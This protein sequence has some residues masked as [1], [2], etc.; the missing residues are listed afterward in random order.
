MYNKNKIMALFA[1][2][3]SVCG[4]TPSGRD[5]TTCSNVVAGTN[6]NVKGQTTNC[7]GGADEGG[8]LGDLVGF[9]A[10]KDKVS[11]SIKRGTPKQDL[12]KLTENKELKVEYPAVGKMKVIS[13]TPTSGRVSNKKVE[14]L[15]VSFSIYNQKQNA[16]L[17]DSSTSA[18]ENL[19]KQLAALKEAQS[20]FNNIIKVY[21][22]IGSEKQWEERA[23]LF[24]KQDP[25]STE[26]STTW[27]IMPNGMLQ[28]T[29]TLYRT[30]ADGKRTEYDAS[31]I[32]LTSME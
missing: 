10:F 16:T 23:E 18:K 4:L 12:G 21:R 9:N 27:T 3:F 17:P 24:T 8:S 6:Q 20:P 26:M 22:K 5:T 7:T 28:S 14:I 15:L 1:A 29:E 13:F 19:D 25:A 2:V 31:S 32:D 30:D 11:W